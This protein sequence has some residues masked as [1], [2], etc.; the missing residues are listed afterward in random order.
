MLGAGGNLL[1]G[2]VEYDVGEAGVFADYFVEQV[3]L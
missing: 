2:R 3:P 1:V